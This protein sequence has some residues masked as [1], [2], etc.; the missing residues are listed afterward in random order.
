MML[1]RMEC[2][3]KAIISGKRRGLCPWLI[4]SFLLP[5]SWIY[6]LFSAIRNWFY[7]KGWMRCYV[8]P[9]PLVISVG[10]IVAGGTGK[11]PATLMLAAEFYE[12]FSLAILSRGYRSKAENLDAPVV[13]CE[14]IGPIFPASYC[15]DE[16]YMYAMRYPKSHVI[17]GSNRKKAARMA[18]KAG[19]Q[20]IL[21]DDALQHRRLARD[22]DVIVVDL[23]DPFGQNHFLPRGY[24]REEVHALKRAHCVLLNHVQDREQ[25]KKV[26]GDLKKY[27]NAPVVGTCYHVSGVHQINGG[28]IT[29]LQG[30]TVGMF[31]SIAHPDYFKRLLEREGAWVAAE[32]CLPDHG[33]I[34]E[35]ELASFA[36][37]CVRKGCEI[38]V[39]TEKDRVKLKEQLNL[40]LPVAWIQIDLKIVEGMNEWQKFLNDAIAKVI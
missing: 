27:T 4:K 2:Y 25:F 39:C 10:N 21:L 33:E 22:F 24:L 15:G 16:P 34:K 11:T 6:R 31:C 14:G 23:N 3:F 26:E 9:I 1:K 38:L 35:K 20:V 18:F 30:K 8:P 13:L 17:V 40:E 19:A 29:S 36:Q 12:K 28:S 32:Y 37:Q 5:L 7:D